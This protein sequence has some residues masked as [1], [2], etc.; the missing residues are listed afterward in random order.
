M[1]NMPKELEEL[2]D[3]LVD[4]SKSSLAPD[5][6][7]YRTFNSCYEAMSKT[8]VPLEDVQILVDGLKRILR[9]SP[10]IGNRSAAHWTAD[11]VLK[12][13]AARTSSEGK[14]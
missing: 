9:D 4:E 8:H 6:V 12:G 13:F 14:V 1:S 10:K 11:T 3:T 5:V 7:A 2:R